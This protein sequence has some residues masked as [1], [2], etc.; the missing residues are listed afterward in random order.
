MIFSFT[1]Y[2]YITIISL[3]ILLYVYTCVCAS[4]LFL[5]I[6]IIIPTTVKKQPEGNNIHCIREKSFI[7]L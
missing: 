7:S 6:N 3:F 4:V 1:I 2:T 5:E